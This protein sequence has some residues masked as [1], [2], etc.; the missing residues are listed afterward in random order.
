MPDFISRL[1]INDFL[2][3]L[4][5]SNYGVDFSEIEQIDKF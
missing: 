2:V 1:Y 3:L 4:F 5:Q